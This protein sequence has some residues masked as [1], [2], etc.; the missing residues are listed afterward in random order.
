MYCQVNNTNAEITLQ[1]AARISIDL[2]NSID[3]MKITKADKDT[4]KVS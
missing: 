4:D 1:A 2:H 3:T